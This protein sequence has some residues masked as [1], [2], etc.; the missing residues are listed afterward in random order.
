M[1]YVMLIRSLFGANLENNR[2]EI[3][4]R[5]TK[6]SSSPRTEL[7]RS[8]SDFTQVTI[9]ASESHQ[10]FHSILL[11]S[12]FPRSG[13]NRYNVRQVQVDDNLV[14]QEMFCERSS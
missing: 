11:R 4:S 14:Q 5:C 6:S 3:Q 8:L 7:T 13:Q 10:S 12:Y 9:K 1:T 2:A